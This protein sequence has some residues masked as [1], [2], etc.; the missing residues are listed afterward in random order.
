M[1]EM[2]L[3]T[4][5]IDKAVWMALLDTVQLL[6]WKIIEITP[7][8]PKRLPK[9]IKAKVTW[10]LKR[11]INY[12]QKWEFEY[13]IG[14]TQNEAEYWKFLEFGTSRMQPRSFLRKWLIDNKDEALKNF[15]KR[16]QQVINS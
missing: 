9:Y 15:S 16:F 6:Q 2:K 7:R 10:N 8:D 3:D 13:I 11:S 12:Q 14:T 4:A 1:S 5:K